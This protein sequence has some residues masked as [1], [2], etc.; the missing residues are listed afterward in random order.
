MLDAHCMHFSLAIVSIWCNIESHLQLLSLALFTNNYNVETDSHVPSFVTNGMEKL[1]MSLESY[2]VS[3][4]ICFKV[5]GFLYPLM[6]TLAHCQDFG[7]CSGM[8]VLWHP[9]PFVV[10]VSTNC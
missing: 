5:A 4:F 10:G 3:E 8:L 1:M 7:E 6:V 9:H 2:E